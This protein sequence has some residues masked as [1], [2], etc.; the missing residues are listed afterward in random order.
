[1][2]S[3]QVVVCLS[4][5]QLVVFLVLYAANYSVLTRGQPP[6]RPSSPRHPPVESST[7][8]KREQE[9]A[10]VRLRDRRA[11]LRVPNGSLSMWDELNADLFAADYS[12]SHPLENE[13]RFPLM[14]REEPDLQPFVEHYVEADCPRSPSPVLVD[15][16]PTGELLVGRRFLSKGRKNFSCGA[17]ELVGGL[18]PN[19]THWEAVGEAIVLPVGRRVFV[20]LDQFLV[21]C[22][23][24]NG[25]ILFEDAFTNIPRKARL[26]PH[27]LDGTPN[28]S[29]SLLVLD[30]T[31]R[32]QFFRHAPQ[33]LRFMR[34]NGFQVLHGFNKV[35]DNSAVNLLPLLAGR[36]VE[37]ET[38]GTAHLVRPDM[39]LTRAQ[40]EEDA[41]K[42]A[43]TLLNQMKGE[44]SCTMFNDDIMTPQLGFMNAYQFKGF[45][46]PPTD[47]F[48]RP[49]YEYLYQR[50]TA[51]KGCVN[52]RL[53]ARRMLEIWERFATT[54][55]RECHFGFTFLTAGTHENPNG[56]ELLDGHLHDALVRLRYRG[57]FEHTA[58]LILGDHGQRISRIQGTYAG[59]VEER[60]PLLAAFLPAKFRAA[61]PQKWRQFVANTVSRPSS[62]VGHLCAQNR[63]ASHYDVHETL[64]EL[65]RLDDARRR[66]V[67]TSLFRALPANR[68]CNDARVP[69]HHCTC[70]ERVEESLIPLKIREEMLAGLREH[71][72][73]T[74]TRLEC[75]RRVEVERPAAFTPFTLNARARA[76]VRTPNQWA[77]HANRTA[78]ENELFDVE[79]EAPLRPLL[80]DAEG[81]CPHAFVLADLCACLGTTG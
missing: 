30:S 67:G 41:W 53:I 33:T 23:D 73:T 29:V 55:A 50:Q 80:L 11:P 72:R 71:V 79:F 43:N 44:C 51:R 19:H 16:L 64:R 34:E 3:G 25:T 14:S 57:A 70:Q 65:L 49:Y 13:C 39:R 78:A 10:N 8:P 2:T 81:R 75:V 17:R 22:V 18:R 37:V 74:V 61:H 63:L 62:P 66:P 24:S 28:V 59:R 36:A 56:V 45:H 32:T 9:A 60:M 26:R 77:A 40:L 12:L 38:Q 6:A 15:Q 27:W 35:G 69:L 54:Y 47:Y 42:Y 21:R 31:A 76:G 7:R 1:M 48:F 58:F 4:A 68:S 5:F 46:E 52:G 20:E